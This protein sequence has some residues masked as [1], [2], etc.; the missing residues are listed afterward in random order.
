MLGCRISDGTRR[1]AQPEGAWKPF[2]GK[3]LGPMV[4]PNPARR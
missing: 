2:D 3:L 1:L 4:Y